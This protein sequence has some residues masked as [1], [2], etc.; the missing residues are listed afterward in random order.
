MKDYGILRWMFGWTPLTADR[1]A[2][3]TL[4]DC[5]FQIVQLNIWLKRPIRPLSGSGTGI[6]SRFSKGW[7]NMRRGRVTSSETRRG[8]GFG[9]L[10]P[11]TKASGLGGWAGSSSGRF[12]AGLPYA[13]GGWERWCLWQLW[14]S[15]KGTELDMAGP[16]YLKHWCIA[17]S[18]A[19]WENQ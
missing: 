15:P 11:G 4:W 16:R 17:I 9:F 14:T 10:V 13:T 1:Q 5:C 7:S 6:Y 19:H 18:D 8:S 3:Q 2:L 12:H